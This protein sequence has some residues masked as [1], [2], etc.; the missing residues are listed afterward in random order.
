MAKMPDIQYMTPTESLGRQDVSLPGRLARSQMAL[1]AGVA[2]VVI[3][4]ADTMQKQDM[5]DGVA[6]AQSEL[7]QLKSVLMTQRLTDVDAFDLTAGVDYKPHDV[8]GN[9]VESISSHTVMENVW[10]DGVKKIVGKYTEG[11]SPGQRREVR[12][13]LGGSISKMG[14]MISA[15][16]YKW[17]LDEITASADEQVSKLVNSATFE[18]KDE[19]KMQAGSIYTDMVRSGFMGA[20]EGMKKYREARSKVD[21][22][23]IMQEIAQ[24]GREAIDNMEEMLARPAAESGLE[25]TLP[26]RKSIY[27]RLDA[28]NAQLERNREKTEKLERER[29][30]NNV[31]I[32]IHETG[33]KTWPEI[34]KAVRDME[35]ASA[36][37]VVTLNQAK[38][39]ET[40]DEAEEGDDTIY[41]SIEVDIL[42]AGMA[43]LGENVSPQAMKDALT[44]KIY[45]AVID[46]EQGRPGITADQAHVLYGR[47]DASMKQKFRPIGYGDAKEQLAG[48]ITKGSVAN[49]GTRDNGPQVLKYNEALRDLNAAIRTGETKDPLAWVEANKH[50]YLAGTTIKNM[51]KADIN[52]AKGFTVLPEVDDISRPDDAPPFNASAAIAKARQAYDAGDLTRETYQKVVDY[53]R[54]QRASH[55]DMLRRRAEREQ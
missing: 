38:M 35:P 40:L 24:G 21:Y 15:Q 9:P 14:G 13:K 1:Y 47:V 52:I 10:T 11:M 18:I 49:M 19:V 36:R 12:G 37:L 33:E 30:T 29:Y 44:N 51:T 43:P 6:G 7:T 5:A 53:W 28:R 45:Q 54:D 22:H 17:R 42:G 4:V 27:G 50:N 25:I 23:V 3:N 31:L 16:A 48:Y 8:D 41:A 39:K 32:D 20:E 2:D 34:R 46:H 26:Q 55:M